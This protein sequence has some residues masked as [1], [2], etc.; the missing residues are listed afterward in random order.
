MTAYAGFDRSDF[1][2]ALA[3]AWLRANTNLCWCG[4]YLPSPSHPGTSWIDADDEALDG[5]GLAPIY[6]G[7]QVTGPGS[8]LVTAAQGAIDGAD[9]A[10]KMGAAGFDPKSCVYLDLENGPPF[11]PAQQAYV[12]AWCDAVS[13]ADFLPGVYCSFMFARVGWFLSDGSFS[14]RAHLDIPRSHGDATS[15]CGNDVPRA[16]PLNERL[17]RRGRLAA[18]R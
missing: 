8:H 12:G 1:P 4:F 6:V 3:M 17:C 14:Q 18:R 9:A 2:G 16:R 13:A 5:W 15:C 7:Q 10:A 11:G